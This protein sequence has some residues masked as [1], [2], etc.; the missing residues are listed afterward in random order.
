M[1][2]TKGAKS[3]SVLFN[4]NIT[5]ALTVRTGNIQDS[6]IEKEITARTDVGTPSEAIYIRIRKDGSVASAQAQKAATDESFGCVAL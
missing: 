5:D 2:I 4:G 3:L 1:T 6:T